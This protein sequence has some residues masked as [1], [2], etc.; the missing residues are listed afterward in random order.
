MSLG[1]AKHMIDDAFTRT[2][3][4]GLSYE[5]AFAG[6]TSFMRRK[7]T[8]DLTGVDLA[9]TGVAFDQAVTN[10]PG[11]RLG[12][13]AVREASTLQAFDPPYGWSADPFSTHAIIDYGDVAF[14]YAHTPSFPAALRAHI[15][16]ILDANVASLTIGGD[17]YITFPILQAYA[18]KY[19]P[20][21]ILQL[22]AHSDT[23][24]DDEI[25]RIDHGTM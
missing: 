12:P 16:G 8:K 10:R 23:W 18:E 9:V 4:R 17:H 24:P 21:S 1:N 13:R 6:A 5:S 20:L 19:G 14:D 22:D 25:D 2:E 7:Y 11:T 3:L 15:K